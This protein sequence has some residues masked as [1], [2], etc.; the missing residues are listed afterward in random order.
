[1]T[2]RGMR[3]LERLTK[4]HWESEADAMPWEALKRHEPDEALRAFERM[5]CA[6]LFLSQ[7]LCSASDRLWLARTAQDE[8]LKL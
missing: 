3:P 8:Q 2:F 4:E 7:S 5:R 6:L 1:M